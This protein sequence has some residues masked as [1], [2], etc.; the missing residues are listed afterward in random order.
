[1]WHRVSASTGGES[2][3]AT[4]YYDLRNV[5]AVCE[6]YAPLG[7]VGTWR[8][9]LTVL[10]AHV[11]QAALSPRRREGLR[12]VRDGWRDFRRGRLGPRR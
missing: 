7:V 4:L 2:S 10:A 9:R 3:P 1:V 12:A 8:R 11:A 6:R 5:L